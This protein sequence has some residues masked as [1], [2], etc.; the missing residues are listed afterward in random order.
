MA[1]DQIALR[2]AIS[3]E[4]ARLLALLWQDIAALRQRVSES[5]QFANA[6]RP[7]LH[8]RAIGTADAPL[9]PAEQDAR[10]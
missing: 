10:S 5:Q 6:A 1:P 8:C 9:P 7:V 2:Q 3:I 4:R